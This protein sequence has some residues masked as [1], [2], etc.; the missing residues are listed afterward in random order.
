LLDL[1][2]VICR[3]IVQRDGPTAYHNLL[4]S[5]TTFWTLRVSVTLTSLL[6]KRE[7]ARTMCPVLHKCQIHIFVIQENPSSYKHIN[8]STRDNV[9]CDLLTFGTMRITFYVLRGV[10]ILMSKGILDD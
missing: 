3:T 1:K 9:V 6:S 5:S 2:S 7:R 8:T 10:L 4:S